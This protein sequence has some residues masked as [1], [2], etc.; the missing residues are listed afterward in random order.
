MFR[1]GSRLE[2]EGGAGRVGAC[3]QVLT[4]DKKQNH[5]CRPNVRGVRRHVE[6]AGPQLVLGGVG[7]GAGG[8]MVSE[9]RWAQSCPN[10]TCAATHAVLICF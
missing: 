5:G 10:D 6:V 1:I 7:A 9:S 8:G 4:R 2:G 3:F